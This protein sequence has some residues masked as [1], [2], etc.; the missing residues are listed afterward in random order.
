MA[1]EA[2]Y[3][4]F[5]LIELGD[6]AVTAYNQMSEK[7][8]KVTLAYLETQSP[9]KAYKQATGH[10]GSVESAG[11]MGR[12]ILKDARCQTVIEAWTKKCLENLDVTDE[13]ILAGMARLAFGDIRSF[14]DEK[15]NMK[16]IRELEKTQADMIAGFECEE[17]YQ[18]VGKEKVFVGYLKKVKL[19]SRQSAL[20]SLGKIRGMFIVTKGGK[21]AEKTKVVQVPA[22]VESIE[23]WKAKNKPAA[24]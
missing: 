15:G 9:S 24:K 2:L 6:A 10:T 14:F 16:P 5:K 12:R 11:Q 13:N 20:D 4:K 7:M 3:D 22:G 1:D 21:E 17:I 18:Q 19:C 8:Q 23:E